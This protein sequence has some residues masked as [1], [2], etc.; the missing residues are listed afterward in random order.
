M[1]DISFADL[2]NNKIGHHPFHIEAFEC[3][4]IYIIRVQNSFPFFY[5]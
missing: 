4:E 2:K 3:I 5:T 1:C